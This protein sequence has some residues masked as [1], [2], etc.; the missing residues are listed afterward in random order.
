ML[1]I[2]PPYK[3]HVKIVMLI[4][5]IATATADTLDIILHVRVCLNQLKFEFTPCRALQAM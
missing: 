4:R 3:I 1:L 2:A 5:G